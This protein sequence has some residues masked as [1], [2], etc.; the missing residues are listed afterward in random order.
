M[1]THIK[2]NEIRRLRHKIDLMAS[3]LL[4]L[5]DNLELLEIAL[6]DLEKES[7]VLAPTGTGAP[8]TL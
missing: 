5:Q 1:T 7:L 2:E 6:F 3:D 8:P 4:C